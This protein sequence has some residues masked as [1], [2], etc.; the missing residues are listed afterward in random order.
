[1]TNRIAKCGCDCFN[2]PT[3]KDNIRT[4][5]NRRNCSSGWKKFLNINLSLE[6]LRAC[7]GCSIND[8]E[9]KTYYVNCKIRK[10][11]MINNIEN[12]AFCIGFPCDELIKA[13]RVQKITNRDVYIKTTGKGISEND[14]RLF[15][16]PYT[17]LH[18]QNK[19]RQTCSDK[20]FKDYKKF[21][22]KAKF[23]H[24]D[25]ING[26]QESLKKIYLMLTSICIEK[27]ISYAKLHTLESKREK[28]MKILWAIG[29]FGT[30]NMESNYIELDGNTF[31]SQK[32]HGMY[33]T[34][35]NI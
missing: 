28:L 20:D 35:L 8:S 6:K 9:R 7:D 3:Y 24:F 10:C 34:L 19:I 25:N 11:A 21:S 32:I 4:M 18:H 31:M 16:E 26:K 15:I 29:C 30:L 22:S 1:M 17:G 23:A 5:E 2:C 33:N 13:H 27:N 12:C 14:Y